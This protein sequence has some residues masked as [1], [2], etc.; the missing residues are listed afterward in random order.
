MEFNVCLGSVYKRVSCRSLNLC[1]FCTNLQS[2]VVQ[3]MNTVSNT[4]NVLV[5]ILIVWFPQ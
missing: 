3:M 4:D 2:D 1:R 5:T